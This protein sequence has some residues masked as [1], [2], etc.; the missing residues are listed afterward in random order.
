[1]YIAVCDDQAEELNDI[2]AL[3]CAWETERN[4]PLHR[5]LFSN[6]VE[7]LDAARREN[8][9]LY[10][11]DVIMSG[12]NGISAARELRG[13]DRTADIVFLTSSTEFA[14]E[15]YR[16]HALDYLLKPV[17]KEILFSLLDK[18]HCRE[19]RPQEALILKTG[20]TVLR[21]LFSELSFVE[22]IG[23][24]LYFNMTNG[25]VREITG[26]MKN[27]ENQLFS[28][29][30]FMRVHRSYI[31]KM[32]Q[33]EALSSSHIRTFSGKSLPV[34]RMLYP[35]LQENYMALLFEQRG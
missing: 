10:L 2:D 5:K 35:Q 4:L 24:R 29:P 22:V 26:S 23:K 20:S 34:S 3:L 11:L 9:T 14:W 28:R 6:A 17:D 31:V 32:L 16:V 7:L 1:M 18:L 21:I 33:V 8:F 30:E 25:D 19:L 27:Y 13:F 12:M 15:S